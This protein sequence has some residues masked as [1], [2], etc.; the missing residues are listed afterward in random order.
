MN[1]CNIV[2]F[3]NVFIFSRLRHH[4][5]EYHV[6]EGEVYDVICSIHRWLN[7]FNELELSV[8]RVLYNN[9]SNANLIFNTSTQLKSR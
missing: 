2:P 7:I 4:N 1:F 9:A 8:E 5:N 6:I 3:F